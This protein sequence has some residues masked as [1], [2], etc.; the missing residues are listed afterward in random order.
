MYAGTGGGVLH[1][2][3]I[4]V[5]A[6]NLGISVDDLNAR[7]TNGETMAQI[8]TASGLTAEEFQAVMV[9]ARSQAVD[10]AVTDG[11]LTQEQADW[12][13]QRGGGL[14]GNRMGANQRQGRGMR[15]A[16]A[17]SMDCP[18]FEQSNP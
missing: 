11:T 6:E 8:A 7:L 13:K 14:M 12:M 3:M 10:Q 9:A 5:F 17:G 16:N 18:Y 1:D 2:A 15:G 4:A